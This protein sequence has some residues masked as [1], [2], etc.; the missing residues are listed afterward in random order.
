MANV[1]S[2][3]RSLTSI[4][5]ESRRVENRIGVIARLSKNII[6]YLSARK[7]LRNDQLRFSP[8]AASNY[9]TSPLGR[10]EPYLTEFLSDVGENPT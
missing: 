8:L 9:A 6:S 5:R 7:A 4:K 10:S 2:L 1:E 3:R